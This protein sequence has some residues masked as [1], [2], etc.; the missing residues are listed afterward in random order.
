M[1]ATAADKAALKELR[2]RRRATVDRARAAIKTQNQRIRRIKGALSDGPRTVPEIAAA[3]G[4]PAPLVLQVVAGLRKYG[5][6]A[7]SEAREGY[8]TYTLAG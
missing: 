3:T 8:Y 1:T 4:L 2:E 7:E 6:L 5:E